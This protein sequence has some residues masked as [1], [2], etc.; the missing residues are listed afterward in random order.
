MKAIQVSQTGGPEVLQYMDV[1]D[2][3]PGPGQA[4]VELRA[5]GVNYT[6]VYTRCGMN[7]P[8][9]PV[10]PGLEGAGVVVEV[11]EGVIEVAPGD[12]VAY[13]SAPRS[14]AEKVVAPSWRLVKLPQ[15]LDAEAGAAAMLQ[16]MTAHYLCHSAYPLKQGD[17]LLVHAGA[18]GTVLLLIQMAKSLGARVITTVSTEAKAQLAQEAGANHTI[19]YTQQDFEEE[20]RGSR[21]VPVSRWYTNRWVRPPSIRAW[22]VWA[23]GATSLRSAIPAAGC[24]RWTRLFSTEGRSS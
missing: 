1:A 2:P 16:G 12:L 10:I 5:I 13:A 11:G 4:L 3:S 6:D 23:A 7:P 21:T 20:V 14:Y 8:T 9:L 24:L 19:L 15:G 22:P 17:T 18:G